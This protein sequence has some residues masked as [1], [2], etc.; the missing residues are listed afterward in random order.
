M[1]GAEAGESDAVLVVLDGPEDSEVDV[2]APDEA[3]A[4]V[5]VAVARE[6]LR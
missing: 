6:S 5:L 4:S 3:P 2:D 1:L